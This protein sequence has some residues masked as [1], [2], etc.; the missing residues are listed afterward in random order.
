MMR[1]SWQSLEKFLKSGRSV[2][3]LLFNGFAEFSKGLLESGGNED[4]VVAES[5]GAA[6]L[7]D[8]MAVAAS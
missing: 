3:A 4:G 1:Q 2:R 5:L 7:A 6:G 8:N